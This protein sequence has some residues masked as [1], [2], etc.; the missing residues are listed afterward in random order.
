MAISYKK[1]AH[2]RDPQT[3]PCGHLALCFSPVKQADLP[4]V[5]LLCRAPRRAPVGTPGRLSASAGDEVS[6]CSME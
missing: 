2:A 6:R 3:D 1:V 4:D 5:L